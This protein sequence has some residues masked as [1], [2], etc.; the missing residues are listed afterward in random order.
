VGDV[1]IAEDRRQEQERCEIALA[2][3]ALLNQSAPSL[4]LVRALLQLIQERT[5]LPW[6]GIRLHQGDGYPLYVAEGESLRLVP[7]SEHACLP[8]PGQKPLPC[9]CGC[10]LVGDPPAGARFTQG[11][12]FWTRDAP[13]IQRGAGSTEALALVP[14]RSGGELVGL[15]HL[16]GPNLLLDLALVS[17]LEPL[18]ASLG[19]ALGRRPGEEEAKLH[20]AELAALAET[21]LSLLE[22]PPGADIYGLIAERLRE[23]VGDAMVAVC[24]YEGEGR[25]VV[26][27]LLGMGKLTDS[28]VAALGRAVDGFSVK[29]SPE[30]ESSLRQGRL[31]KM[32][33]DLYELVNGALPQMVCRAIERVI[34]IDSVHAIGFVRKGRLLGSMALVVRRGGRPVNLPLIEA[35]TTLASV[36]LERHLAEQERAQIEEQLL[37]SQRLEAIGTLAG[38]VAHDFNNML[39]VILSLSA[40]AAQELP[41]G[42][43]LRADLEEIQRA[44]QRAERL[45]RQ[46]LAFARR[47][48]MRLEVVDLNEVVRT[49]KGMLGRLLGEDIEVRLEL[50]EGPAR[51]GV[52]VGQMEQ[53]IV[54]LATN[55]RDAMPDGGM[56]RI[57][58]EVSAD[59]G[60]RSALLT[61]SDTGQGMDPQTC[62]RAL[63]PFF[64]T[65]AKGRGTGLGLSTAYGIVE[66]FGG[67]LCVESAP[68]E[69]T[70]VR[71]HLPWAEGDWVRVEPKSPS[72]QHA[73][74]GDETILV[75]EDEEVVRR[76]ALRV[77]KQRGYTVLAARDGLEAQRIANEH[78]GPIHLLLTDLVMP[79][80]SGG[81]TARLLVAKRPELRVLFMSGYI[82]RSRDLLDEHAV[83][84]EKPFTGSLLAAAVRRALDGQ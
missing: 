63:E 35:F 60:E 78:P 44:A 27:S 22:L 59:D 45:T 58:V 76:L 81:E 38:A 72:P 73:S 29:L 57:R 71:I 64:T 55:A 80:M 18:A 7:E 34:Q 23:I 11:G 14:L 4:D 15:L 10:L 12:S 77:L 69:G 19:V 65:K 31:A 79:G 83:I 62:R 33:G 50:G 20:A 13:A 84:L 37:H 21:G 36:A 41:E 61:V 2:A 26:R 8:A 5:G 49:I 82:D 56:L 28:L 40:I 47:Q 25:I 16:R 30:I 66:Q 17:F 75:T 70:T 74:Q 42:Q 39:T 54:N 67:R 24:R 43:P 3:L 46:L 48:V 52:D 53:V 9:L 32:G 1:R 68:G 6:V 51:V